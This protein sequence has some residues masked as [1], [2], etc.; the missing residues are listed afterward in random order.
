MI[1]DFFESLLAEFGKLI[2]LPLR[3]DKHGACLLRINETLRVQIEWNF[4]KQ[5]VLIASLL[6]ELPPGK[7]R[8]EML[9]EGL[10]ANTDEKRLGDF[11]YAEKT[12]ELC[13]FAY[14][15]QENLSGESLLLFLNDFIPFA[16]GWQKAVETGQIPTAPLR[17]PSPFSPTKL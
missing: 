3:L 12:G 2:N 15:P 10:K 11:C 1:V 16:S 6:G 17:A 14:L 13:L 4:S 5:A 9:K 8:E 7:Y